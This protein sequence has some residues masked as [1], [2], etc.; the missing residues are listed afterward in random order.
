MKLCPYPVVGALISAALMTACSGDTL[1]TQ[2]D[3]GS[4]APQADISV[5]PNTWGA[6]PSMST[7]RYAPV[8]ATVD[9]IIY[10][11]G[12]YR[13]DSALRTVEAYRPGFI[14]A[15]WTSRAQ[16][17]AK[18]LASSGAGVIGGKIYVTGG[19]NN[20]DT[21][22]TSLFVYDPS[23]DSWATKAPIPVPTADGA[24]GAISG[25]LYVFTPSNLS[26]QQPRSFYRYNPNNDGWTELTPPPHD[27]V[28]PAAG[29]I[30]GKLYLAGGRSAAGGFYSSTLDM[31][32]P[33]TGTWQTK[34]SMPTARGYIAGR[35][36]N[37]KLY[38][39]G[40]VDNLGTQLA[41][42]EVYD[43]ATDSWATKAGMP[44][45]RGGLAAASANG[46]LYALGGRAPNAIVKTNEAYYP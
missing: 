42:L 28:A 13:G 34:A 19:F 3:G 30:D 43:P 9:G 4:P 22:T 29:V 31:Y 46:V 23:A 26:P 37:G 10:V 8:A 14:V 12:G 2:P 35:V 44:T 24:S 18:R 25:R 20:N 36:I 45:A 6:R 15:P 5:A 38:V 33:A 21:R 11:I 27:H 16:L 1:P 32:D 39:L 17:P 7:R 41:T 40:G